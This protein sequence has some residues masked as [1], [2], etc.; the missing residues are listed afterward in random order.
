MSYQ[1]QPQ[2]GYYGPPPGQGGQYP[3]PQQQVRLQRIFLRKWMVVADKI[4]HRCT[5]PKARRRR[6]KN[7]RRTGDVWLLGEFLRAFPN[8]KGANS[9]TMRLVW[10]RCAAVGCV[11]R[12]ASAV[13]TASIAAVKKSGLCDMITF[14]T[15][16]PLLFWCLCEDIL[17]G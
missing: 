1:Q 16:I 4:R 17:C 6:R 13:L 12:R 8:Y 7:R 10:R 9:L 5:T 2:P 15:I 3:P 14:L 11:E